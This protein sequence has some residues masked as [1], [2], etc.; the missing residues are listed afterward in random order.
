MKFSSDLFLRVLILKN[1]LQCNC[2]NLKMKVLNIKIVLGIIKISI[3]TNN[4][5][6][7]IID[8]YTIPIQ[9]SSLPK[10]T[11]NLEWKKCRTSGIYF[12]IIFEPQCYVQQSGI[13]NN[14]TA[15][16]SHQLLYNLTSRLSVMSKIVDN[17]RTEVLKFENKKWNHLSF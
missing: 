5:W 12:Y 2:L 7:P 15:A 11:S 1:L 3:C 10:N 13:F 9:P 16:I 4:A 14:R 6:Y 17:F 8:T